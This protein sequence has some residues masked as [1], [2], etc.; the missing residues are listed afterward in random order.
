[1]ANVPA[2]DETKPFAKILCEAERRNV[3][4]G[5][6]QD[7]RVYDI[8]RNFRSYSNSPDGRAAQA[9]DEHL[10][11]ARTAAPPPAAAPAP[12]QSGDLE[13]Q[14]KSL[15]ANVLKNMVA[16]EGLEPATGAGMKAKNIKILLDLAAQSSA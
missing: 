2:F 8:E 15:H 16:E 6:I 1:M 10:P 7:G 9:A 13:A 12:A 3:D 4:G 5:Y 11:S 14:L